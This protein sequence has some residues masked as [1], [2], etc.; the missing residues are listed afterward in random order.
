M[1]L[2]T[3]AE[4]LS[5]HWI[6]GNILYKAWPTGT[7][8]GK[9]YFIPL[10][11]SIQEISHLWQSDFP[12]VNLFSNKHKPFEKVLR[13]VP[14]NIQPIAIAEFPHHCVKGEC[15][16]ALS[17][18]W[19]QTLFVVEKL[20]CPKDFSLSSNFFDRDSCAFSF[21]CVFFCLW[22]FFT[23]NNNNTT[24]PTMW[25]QKYQELKEKKS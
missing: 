20:F 12:P 24:I 9:D 5:A 13:L 2:W 1:T 10:P 15:L 21:S 17:W 22:D 7:W 3:Y 25:R 14:V 11:I 6:N 23:G 4:V 19:L 16:E 18:F 8:F